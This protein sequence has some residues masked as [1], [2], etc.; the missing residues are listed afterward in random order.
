ML[1][2]WCSHTHG[3]FVFFLIY[4]VQVLTTG[5][6]LP[7][8]DVWSYGVLAWETLTLGSVRPYA[9]TP[10]SGLV[11]FLESGGRLPQPASCPPALYSI[12]Q[13]VWSRDP[14]H[15]PRFTEIRMRLEEE[16]RRDVS[17]HPE[18]AARMERDLGKV[19]LARERRAYGEE[20]SSDE[21]DDGNTE[22]I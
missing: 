7:A 13:D 19:L 11:A 5:R 20:C 10:T 21:E 16:L 12:L 3:G 18:L 8:S 9:D 1:W 4:F 6:Y 14:A 2:S 17:A 15:R 22:L